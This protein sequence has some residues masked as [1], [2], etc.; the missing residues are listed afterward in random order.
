MRLGAAGASRRRL[1]LG[2]AAGLIAALASAWLL[3]G[4]PGRL[5]VRPPEETDPL[6]EELR[7]ALAAGAPEARLLQ[8]GNRWLRAREA[9]LVGRDEELLQALDELASEAAERCPAVHG[10]CRL[11]EA[12]WTRALAVAGGLSRASRADVLSSLA[13]LDYR[14]GRWQA[15]ETRD[16]QVVAL[17]RESGDRAAL[18]NALLDLANNLFYQGRYGEA[19]AL[20]DEALANHA[21]VGRADPLDLADAF[22]T[23]GEL[24]RVGGEYADAEASFQKA[25]QHASRADV[26]GSL[27]WLDYRQGRW[28]AAEKRDRQVV[29]LRRESGD[30][31]ALANA[32]LDLAN[33]L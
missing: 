33:N 10:A 24:R 5:A 16:R 18:A 25:L 21:P 11:A 23:L 17:R 14:Q 31:A 7:S 3:L 8:L 20:V 1:A 26:L 32:L 13:W 15:A 12:L 27:A 6:A 4:P 19:Q 9:A 2:L 29:A 22:V 28:Q 30:R